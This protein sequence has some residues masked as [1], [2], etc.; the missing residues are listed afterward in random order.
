MSLLSENVYV[1]NNYFHRKR[2]SKDKKGNRKRKIM[3]II[4][5]ATL[6]VILRDEFFISYTSGDFVVFKMGNNGVTK[7][8]DI[9]DTNMRVNLLLRRVKHAYSRCL[10]QF[11]LCLDTIWS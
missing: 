7:V 9:D 4:V 8:V 3:M 1:L 2:E 11:N 6:H 5:S 10:F